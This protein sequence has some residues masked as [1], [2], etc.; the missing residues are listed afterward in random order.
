ME[1][2]IKSSPDLEKARDEKC[3]PV[4]QEILKDM[5]EHLLVPNPDDP[6]AHDDLIMFILRRALETDM[7][8]TT[9]IQYLLQL[10]LGGFSGF[11]T[12]IHSCE[13]APID[14]ERYIT[15]GK[16]M[17]AI[18][19]GANVRLTN[20]TPADTTADFAGAKETLHALI[21]AE[22]L[23]KIEIRYI[24]DNIWESVKVVNNDISE[25]LARS[26]E[27]AE[28]KIFGNEFMSDLTLGQ[29]NKVLINDI[30]IE[31]AKKESGSDIPLEGDALP[32]SGDGQVAPPQQVME[33][34]PA[35]VID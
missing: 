17:L 22:N 24:M 16:K 34:D 32:P 11:N 19:A 31:Y 26:T 30:R 7:N 20:V 12:T 10:V 27:K 28:A 15:I 4:A 35:S 9:E 33:R 25:S 5:V 18:L 29:V 3:I 6:H 14:E 13:F 23:T 2:N 1:P 21:N 8:I